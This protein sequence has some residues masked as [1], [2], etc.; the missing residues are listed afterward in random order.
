MVTN[1]TPEIGLIDMVQTSADDVSDTVRFY[2]NVLGA[3]VQREGDQWSRLRIGGIDIGIHQTPTPI[4]GWMPVFR[5]SDIVAVK[6]AV[7]ASHQ[8]I[9]QD[10]NDIPGGVML[11]FSDPAGNAIQVVQI[12][13]SSD[14]IS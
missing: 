6:A 9:L 14:Q 5:V 12:G 11:A 3:K 7:Q 10:Y 8:P 13:L 1:S 2:S 4:S